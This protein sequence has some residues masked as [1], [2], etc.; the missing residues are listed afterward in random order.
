M[1]AKSQDH[2]PQFLKRR[3]RR[4][5]ADRTKVLLLTSK[6]C[7]ACPNHTSLIS[8][9]LS[10]EVHVDPQ[11]SW[12]CPALSCWSCA[13]SSRFRKVSSSTWFQELGSFSQSQQPGS[14]FHSC[15]GW[16][17]QETCTTWTC[18]QSRWCCTSRFCLIWQLLPLQTTS[19]RRLGEMGNAKLSL[20][21]LR[22]LD[23]LCTL[24]KFKMYAW[25]WIIALSL[26][27][28]SSPTP[29]LNRLYESLTV[30]DIH[31]I[32]EGSCG[33]SALI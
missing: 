22:G 33:C 3:E 21:P 25:K 26:L 20:S 10:E 27:V 12:S 2:E 9:Q 13:P 19:Y 30:F 8:W 15:R 32:F 11:G 28:Y 18:L 16:R 23:N 6:A 24:I 4:A 17:W 5:E 14:I 7:V 31:H 29:S 1:W